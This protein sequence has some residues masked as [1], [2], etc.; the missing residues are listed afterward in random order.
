MV[1]ADQSL[2]TVVVDCGRKI[3]IVGSPLIPSRKLISLVVV[4][5]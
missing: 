2:M 1:R 3:S 5:V 4:L